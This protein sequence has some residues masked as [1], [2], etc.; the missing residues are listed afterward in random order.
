MGQEHEVPIDE[1]KGWKAKL[2]KALLKGLG[3]QTKG[4]AVYLLDKENSQN[5]KELLSGFEYFLPSPMLLNTGSIM[6]K[7]D[8]KYVSLRITQKTKEENSFKVALVFSP[9]FKPQNSFLT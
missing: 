2:R 5:N 7:A 9:N 8:L 6:K 4:K 3:S 1:L